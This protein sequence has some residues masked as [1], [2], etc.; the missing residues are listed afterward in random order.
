MTVEALRKE[1]EE[2]I[3]VPLGGCKRYNGKRPKSWLPNI[4]SVIDSTSVIFTN[5]A[6]NPVEIFSGRR[7]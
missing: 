3:G 4:A 7:G 5:V 2:I 6:K 1:F